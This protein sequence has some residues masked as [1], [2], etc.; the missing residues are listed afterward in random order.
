M[1]VSAARLLVGNVLSHPAT[2]GQAPYTLWSV[3]RSEHEGWPRQ[4]SY[5]VDGVEKYLHGS[6]G[7]GYIRYLYI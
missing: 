5:R 2:Q 3:P 7:I 6:Q 1:A 4:L